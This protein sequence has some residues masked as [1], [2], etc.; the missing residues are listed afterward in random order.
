M[1]NFSERLYV[2]SSNASEPPHHEAAHGS[3]H[4]RFP[5]RT[6]PLVIFAHPPVLIDPGDR[7]L[8]HPPPRQ[9]LEA[10]GHE[11]L[12]VDLLGPLRSPQLGH[13]LGDRLLGLAHDLYA[14]AQRLLRP[15]A[16]PFPRS[17]HPTI[18]ASNARSR[19][20]PT[21]IGASAR[22]GRLPSRCEP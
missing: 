10:F 20:A 18:G 2:K 19:S 3:V 15:T 8:H 14:H 13:L 21:P 9:H 4:Q 5:A 6:Q 12:P 1:M 11:P 22:P 17:R 16:C 7:P